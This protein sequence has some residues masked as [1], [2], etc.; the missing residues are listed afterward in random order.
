MELIYFLIAV[1]AIA[2]LGCIWGLIQLNKTSH[3]ETGNIAWAKLIVHNMEEDIFLSFAGYPVSIKSHSQ[4]LIE[5]GFLI[6]Y[7]LYLS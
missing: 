6:M 4:H 2:A 3:E 5:N 7:M 1:S